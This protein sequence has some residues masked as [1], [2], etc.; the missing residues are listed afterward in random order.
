MYIISDLHGSKGRHIELCKQAEKSNTVTLQ[1]GDLG[2]DY[3]YL[4]S[5]DY[6]KHKF[7]GGNHDNYNLI[8]KG[9]QHHLGD[10]GISDHGGYEFFWVRGEFSI[11]YRMREQ[12]YYAGLWPMTFFKDD[13]EIKHSEHPNVL[14]EYA[15][16]INTNKKLG[17]KSV[18]ISHGCP[19]SI[20]RRIGNPKVLEHFGFDPDTFST[21]TQDLLE[22]MLERYPPDLWIF[23]HFHQNRD[24]MYESTRFVCIKDN[25]YLSID[26]GDL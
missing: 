14:R 9:I 16:Y 23:G 5:I 6:T 8:N 3:D 11:D 21:F 24:F 20:A 18:V 1:I 15:S 17:H 25:E 19:R 4:K 22:S 2:Y 7:F 12:K 10:Y 13:E 26:L